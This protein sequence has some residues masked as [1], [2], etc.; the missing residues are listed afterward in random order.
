MSLNE[1][2]FARA[3][4]VIPGGV[5]SPVRSFRSVGG[6]PYFVSRAEGPYVWDSEGTRYIDYVM[7]CLLYTSPSPRDMRRARMPSSA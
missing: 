7:S 2:Y 1:D 4:Q 6:T 5:N 3:N